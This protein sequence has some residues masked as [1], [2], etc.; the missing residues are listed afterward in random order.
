[1]VVQIRIEN[2]EVEPWKIGAGR[3]HLVPHVR[4]PCSDFDHRL[5]V[6]HKT[7]TSRRPDILP[8][9]TNSSPSSQLIPLNTFSFQL[10]HNASR[11]TRHDSF[12]PLSSETLFHHSS[13]TDKSRCPRRCWY[14][15]PR[16]RI[17]LHLITRISY[18]MQLDCRVI[19]WD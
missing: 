18:S 11:S 16:P 8:I 14:F 3:L 5:I 1:V 6:P 13:R 19:F 4:P 7:L 9:I 10:L 15:P 2:P 17:S 12:V